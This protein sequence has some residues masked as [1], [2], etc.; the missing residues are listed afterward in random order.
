M[1]FSTR[2]EELSF[3]KRLWQSLPTVCPKCG[4]VQL[5]LLHKKAKKSDCDWQC[6][7]CGEIYR[8]IN[9]L[10]ELLDK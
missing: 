8:T 2:D 10:Y 6:P 9:M 4:K 5:E 7:G 1:Y 3:I